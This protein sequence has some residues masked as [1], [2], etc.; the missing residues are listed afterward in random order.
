MLLNRVVCPANCNSVAFT[1]DGVIAG[2]DAGEVVVTENSSGETLRDIPFVTASPAIDIPGNHEYQITCPCC[3][4][5]F[6]PPH[7][8][9]EEIA[10]TEPYPSLVVHDDNNDRRNLSCPKCHNTLRL[11]HFLI[12]PQKLE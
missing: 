5:H 9:T 8:Y 1:R 10:T 6:A 11:N 4:S 2:L 3:G 12:C 7:Y